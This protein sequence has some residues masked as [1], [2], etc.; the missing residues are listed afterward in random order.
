[1]PCP[2]WIPESI[3]KIADERQNRSH[4]GRREP[5]RIQ[6]FIT[7]SSQSFPQIR[8]HLLDEDIFGM[9][10]GRYWNERFQKTLIFPGILGNTK[11]LL[12]LT[13]RSFFQHPFSRRHGG[14]RRHGGKTKTDWKDRERQKRGVSP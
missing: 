7:P 3:L 9:T 4:R 2:L 12:L 14:A 1:M 6:V 5:Q 8:I 13:I 11:N 10:M